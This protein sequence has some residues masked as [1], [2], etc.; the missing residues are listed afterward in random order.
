VSGE[1]DL[2]YGHGESPFVGQRFRGRVARAVVSGRT[3][4]LDGE[5]ISRPVG[6][7]LRPRKRIG[8]NP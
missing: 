2:F 8:A 5:M 7:L 4:F 1:D 3:V 6:R